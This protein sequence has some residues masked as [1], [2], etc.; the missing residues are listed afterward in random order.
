[1]HSIIR[2][3]SDVDI[4]ECVCGWRT[5]RLRG[6]LRPG[7][8][9]PPP[10]ISSPWTCRPQMITCRNPADN[11]KSSIDFQE[12]KTDQRTRLIKRVKTLRQ[13]TCFLKI[14][15]FC[16]RCSFILSF[17]LLSGRGRRCAGKMWQ[18]N[19]RSITISFCSEP[20]HDVYNK[21]T[22]RVIH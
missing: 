17:G 8:S 2:P 11:T 20:S 18:P 21:W 13:F 19:A 22:E 7:A 14:T 6:N 9:P 12:T 1:M 5:D 15:E 16:C 3:W 10:P 4:A